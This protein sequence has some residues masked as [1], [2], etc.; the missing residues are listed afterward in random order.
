MR[1][2]LRIQK[3][4]KAVLNGKKTVTFHSGGQRFTTNINS[5]K[6]VGIEDP[7]N[8]IGKTITVDTYEIGEKLV[9]GSIYEGREGGN[10]I[11]EILAVPE[12]TQQELIA[13]SVGR[14]MAALLL[15]SMAPAAAVNSPQN[16]EEEDNNLDENAAPAEQAPATVEAANE[17]A[18]VQAAAAPV[19]AVAEAAV[20]DE[21][22]PA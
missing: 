7:F 15:Q 5:L 4:Q 9:D 3:V 1:K 6:V 12:R 22:L 17:A 14:H 8:L 10:L 2:N 13:D 11:K 20:L 21:Q 19:E 16:A 18:P